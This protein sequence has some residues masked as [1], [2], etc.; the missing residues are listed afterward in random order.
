M[1]IIKGF[2]NAEN[3]IERSIRSIMGKTYKNFKCYITH[4]MSTDNL[5]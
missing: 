4:D 5:L 1:A 3:Y 2:Y